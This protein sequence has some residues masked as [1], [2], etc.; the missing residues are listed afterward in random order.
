MRP[1]CDAT[2]LFVALK[3]FAI[4]IQYLDYVQSSTRYRQPLDSSACPGS[5]PGRQKENA[6]DFPSPG[7]E[8]GPQGFS[9]EV[10]T[11][12]PNR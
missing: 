10:R 12:Y 2:T 6:V 11:L 9:W 4:C 7:I 8:P 1:K 3:L 5:I